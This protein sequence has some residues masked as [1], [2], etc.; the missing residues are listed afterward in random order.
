[1]SK[2]P[3]SQLVYVS[4]SLVTHARELMD[5]IDRSRERNAACGV[6]G[7]LLYTGGLFAQILEGDR[8]EIDT[9]M[10]SIQRDH[11]HTG[12][13]VLVV[14]TRAERDF[15]R[16]TMAFNEYP[17][18]EGTLGVLVDMPAAS[19]GRQQVDGLLD[20]MYQRAL[21]SE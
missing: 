1:M 10:I 11:R 8:S 5:I 12:V 16:W 9:L 18:A 4:R 2:Q 6:T 7:G 13:N 20:I 3:I 17:G 21:L 15:A 19:V 14:R